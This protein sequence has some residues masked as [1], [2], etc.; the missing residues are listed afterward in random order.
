[1][2]IFRKRLIVETI[3]Y[4]ATVLF[5]TV[6]IITVVK[7]L[8]LLRRAVQGHLPV[9]GLGMIF[10]LKLAT[11]IDVILTPVLYIAILL[12]LIRWN[13]DH[14]IT[15]YST[16]GI[17]PLGYLVPAGILSAVAVVL[18]S[19]FSLVISPM[20]E[21][22]YLKEIEIYKQSVKSLPF[23][24]GQFRQIDSEQDVIYFG[25][26]D[27]G[28]KDPIRIFYHTGSASEKIVTVAEYGTYSFDFGSG[29]ESIE[30]LNGTQ[31]NL[32]PS[33]RTYRRADF[34]ALRERI[35]T[36]KFK[37]D[38]ILP[39]AKQTSQ[40]VKSDEIED[41]AELAWRLSKII[42]VPIVVML[43]FIFGSSPRR[44][45]ST[46]NLAGP[47]L[48]YFIYSS[49]S[50]FT[51]DAIRNESLNSIHYQWLPH[52]AVLAIMVWILVCDYGNRSISSFSLKI[53]R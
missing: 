4:C 15:V 13:R 53:R 48:I 21:L 46:L 33:D 40:L 24:K 22:G 16:S 1:M 35:P 18:I 36:G 32:R 23:E 5:M 49:L 51:N 26:H 38:N 31:Y 20:A 44:F 29:Y 42:T 17:G 25:Q 10:A 41:R 27:E 28:Q 37:L 19:V 34:S 11:F 50:G 30:I 45:K 52:L 47:I 3:S 6:G 14:E 39:K 2:Q 8:A 12:V 9:D 7:L 43:A